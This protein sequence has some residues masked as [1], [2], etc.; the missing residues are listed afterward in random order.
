MKFN[1][2]K[3]QLCCNLTKEKE[4]TNM[5]NDVNI[6]AVERERERERERATL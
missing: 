2:V 5:I 4:G 6:G 3:S 1:I